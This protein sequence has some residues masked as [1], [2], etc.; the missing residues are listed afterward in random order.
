MHNWKHISQERLRWEEE[1]LESEKQTDTRLRQ[2]IAVETGEVKKELLEIEKKVMTWDTKRFLLADLLGHIQ[3]AKQAIA[4]K[5]YTANEDKARLQ[6]LGHLLEHR[7]Q[8]RVE[9]EAQ[10]KH[11]Q[12]EY[13]NTLEKVVKAQ[14]EQLSED[15][16][17]ISTARKQIKKLRAGETANANSLRVARLANENLQ[18]EWDIAQQSATEHEA[19]VVESQRRNAELIRRRDEMLE[20]LTLQREKELAVKDKEISQLVS[21]LN[22]ESAQRDAEVAKLQGSLN[23][24]RPAYDSRGDAVKMYEDIMVEQN[25][26]LKSLQN[27]HQSIR[28]AY[29]STQA[30]LEKCLTSAN[31]VDS[32]EAKEVL[33]AV[34]GTMAGA[35]GETEGPLAEIAGAIKDAVTQAL[36]PQL[37]KGQEPVPVV[38]TTQDTSQ[39]TSAVSETFKNLKKVLGAGAAAATGA[40]TTAESESYPPVPS[41]WDNEPEVLAADFEKL[42]SKLRRAPDAKVST[43]ADKPLE[44]TL[45]ASWENAATARKIHK[46]SVQLPGSLGEKVRSLA[47]ELHD[48]HFGMAGLA[49]A[50]DEISNL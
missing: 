41:H 37:G 49:G 10:L 12:E 15:K 21:R 3:S 17:A 38:D 48:V 16:T 2:A 31:H 8:E 24:L 23:S 4:N 9:Q 39:E 13:H 34:Q 14:E 45:A 35:A 29:H 6:D 46:K 22:E 40:Q 33:E 11:V 28:K 7:A 1:K 25:H 32:T 19:Q 18:A 42:M 20:R 50:L 26:E 43:K 36:G 5:K 44:D 30:D 47:T 27:A